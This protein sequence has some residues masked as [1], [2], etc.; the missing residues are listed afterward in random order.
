MTVYNDLAEPLAIPGS[1]GRLESAGPE[2]QLQQHEVVDGNDP[3]LSVSLNLRRHASPKTD[4]HGRVLIPKRYLNFA[5][6]SALFNFYQI[7]EPSPQQ[8]SRST[9][10][11]AWGKWSRIMAFK[12]KGENSKCNICARLTV[13]RAEAVKPSERLRV[14]A[15]KR[16][17]LDCVMADRS[18][19]V[20]CNKLA[21]RA[22]VWLTKQNHSSM[23]KLMLDGMDQSKFSIPR[24]KD[25][26][27]T[28]SWSKCWRPSIHV[29]GCICF[30]QFEYYAI[31]RPDQAKDSNMNATITCRV[32]DLLHTKL[33]S[34]GPEYS[35]PPE[36]VVMCDNT[37][38]EAKNAFYASYLSTLVGKQLFKQVECHFLQVNHTHNELDQRFSSMASVIKG[39][40]C[41]EDIA[42]LVEY[43]KDHMKA[44][45]NR[46]IVIEELT[47]TMDFKTWLGDANLHVQGLTSTHLEPHANHVWRFTPRTEVDP[48]HGAIECHHPDWRGLPE[49]PQDVILTVKHTTLLMLLHRCKALGLNGSSPGLAPLWSSVTRIWVHCMESSNR[50][51]EALT[52]MKLSSRGSLRKANNLIQ[53]VFML[54]NLKSL[55]L[56]DSSAFVQRWN[57]MSSKTFQIVGRK[58]SALKLLLEQTPQSVLTLILDHV[59]M[60]GWESCVW[61]D[62]NLGSKKIFSGFQFSCSKKSWLPRLR[63]T[64]ESMM[65]MVKFLQACHEQKASYMR[66]K[67]DTQAVE[68]AAVKATLCWHLGQELLQQVPV[69]PNKLQAEWYDNF[70]SGENSVDGE[71]QALLMDKSD[72]FDVKRDCPSLRKLVEDHKFSKPV[73]MD[74]V[75]EVSLQV[76]KFALIMKQLKYDVQVYTTWTRKVSSV[77]SAQEHQ[78]HM[79]L[80]ERRKR[81]L[82]VADQF[83]SR[84]VKLLV[85]QK[86][87]EL[88]IAEIMN[89]KRDVTQKLSVPADEIYTLVWWN[90]TSPCLIPAH[91]YQQ[92]VSLLAWALNDQ[93][94]SMALV[95]MPTFS[96]SKGKLVLEESQLLQKLSAG[97]HNIDWQW[98]LLF[99][100][101]SDARDLRPLVYTGRFVFPSPLELQ[102]NPWFS[103]DLRKTQRT[104][105]QKQLAAKEMREVECVA[106][107]SLPTTTDTRDILH[108]APKYWQVG[109]T[110]CSAVLTSAF[111]GVQPEPGATLVLDLYPRNGDMC[112]AFCDLRSHRNNVQYI[113]L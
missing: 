69:D 10:R 40:A 110:A 105:E 28:S 113:A 34:Q 37:P 55:G 12:N 66:K 64:D 30:G 93:M 102:K 84:N 67:P 74:T 111:T 54:Q 108:G 48:A 62:D 78:R 24:R 19:S 22:D 44:A 6:E 86:K 27:G 16:Q 42:D 8:V 46:E 49:H 109:S 52:N 29:T 104:V 43:L 59:N 90:V 71:L 4:P 92:S 9:F 33:Q 73:A 100:E 41:L 83:L 76:D 58:A 96:Y 97:N 21:S 36:L 107:D 13:E 75:E 31:M 45:V 50:I 35:F 18:V 60:H 26:S 81:C 101:R 61:S 47:N 20:R 51:D 5:D 1:E 7:D 68:D 99:S 3:L 38:R 57:K 70:G 63:T 53:L 15:A 89:A 98:H 91:I 112:E 65:L 87:V 14:D 77:K 85:W 95:L 56:S 39:A 103:C 23:C 17:H 32:L 2:E 79:W 25:M 11:K 82:A 88:A 80:L 72:T 94:K 106:E